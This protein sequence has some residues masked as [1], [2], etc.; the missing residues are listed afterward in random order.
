M[1]APLFYIYLALTNGKE[2]LIIIVELTTIKYNKEVNP[3]LPFPKISFH[4]EQSFK[5][6]KKGYEKSTLH[7]HQ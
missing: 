5:I 1:Y 3:G 7:H 4:V 2:I 6:N